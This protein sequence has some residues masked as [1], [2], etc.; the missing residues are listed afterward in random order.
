P[1][2][3]RHVLRRVRPRRDAREGEG[4]MTK[5]TDASD[6]GGQPA[7]PFEVWRKFYEANEQ[8]W[9]RAAK[10]T[11][12]TE[13]FAQ[14]Q[15]KMLETFLALELMRGV[16]TAKDAPVGQTPKTV[17]WRKNKSRLYR[18]TRGAPATRR[19]PVFL[20]LPLIN[21][22]YILDL[23]PGNSF[24]EFLLAQGHDVYLLD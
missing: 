13:A 17:A 18:Y 5:R 3:D 10:D 14:A 7:D 2:G 16:A 6:A 23:R 24:V 4:L 15:A 9:S 20:A 11:T 12:N 22:A 21:R 8:I 1:P 19:T